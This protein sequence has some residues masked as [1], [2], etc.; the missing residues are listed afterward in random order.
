MPRFHRV[1]V[2]MGGVSSEREVS[3][4]SGQAVVKG[5]CEA[6]CEAVPVVLEREAVEGLPAGTE[7]V[8]LALH[9]GYGENGGVQADLDR[10]GVPYTGS[11]AA[12]SRLAMDKI[13][14]KRVLS[15]HAVPTPAHEVLSAGEG[16]GRMAL[17]LV[18]KP[19]RDGSSVGVTLVRSPGEWAPALAAAR[20]IDPEVLVERYIPGREWTVGVVGGEALPVIE[21][22]AANDWYG[23]DAKYGTGDTVYLFPDDRAEEGL[24]ARCRELAQATFQAVGARGLGRVDFRVTPAGEPYVLELNTIPGFTATSLLPKAAAKAGMSFSALCTRI[25]D[26]AC[27]DRP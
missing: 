23:Y 11:G 17:P 9:G 6:G 14:T 16:R 12:A 27:F 25:L 15:A 22:R 10:M 7:A 20:A 5:L 18:V 26:L 1:A 24:R 19:Q 2:L 3:L 4:R 8:F 21:I 13:A